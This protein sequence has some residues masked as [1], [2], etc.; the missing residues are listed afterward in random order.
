MVTITRIEKIVGRQNEERIKEHLDG[1]SYDTC[2]KLNNKEKFALQVHIR[3]HRCNPVL[4]LISC[5]RLQKLYEEKEFRID[6]IKGSGIGIAFVMV[7][8][9]CGDRCDITDYSRW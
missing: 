5:F 8:K 3:E 1:Y 9:T 7:C 4:H 6:E 2:E